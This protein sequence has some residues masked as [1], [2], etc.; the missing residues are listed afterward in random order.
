MH[1]IGDYYYLSLLGRRFLLGV[2]LC[3][4]FVGG[5]HWKKRKKQEKDT[6]SC[7][8]DA[9]M[10]FMFVYFALSVYCLVSECVS[11]I[12]R[13][14]FKYIYRNTRTIRLFCLCHTKQTRLCR[15]FWI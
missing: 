4:V 11:R 9:K 6:I 3:A 2:F 15:G 12:N 14:N 7:G 8:I 1:G 10:L 5:I 13:A